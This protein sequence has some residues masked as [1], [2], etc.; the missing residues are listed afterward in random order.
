MV[1]HSDFTAI[2]FH[3][4]ISHNVAH[5]HGVSCV[6]VCLFCNMREHGFLMESHD[7]HCF[8]LITVILK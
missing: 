6:C 2:T 5:C 1:T 7:C 3:S 4:C 8:A